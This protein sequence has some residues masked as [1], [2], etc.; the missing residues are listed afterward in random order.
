FL[1]LLGGVLVGV[2]LD[3]PET[4]FWSMSDAAA[5]PLSSWPAYRSAATFLGIAAA[6]CGARWIWRGNPLDAALAIALVLALAAV[7]SRAPAVWLGASA[8]VLLLGLLLT[9]Y[10]MAFIDQL[11]GLPNRR[12]LDETLARLSGD[13]ALAM[14][15]VD[16]FKSFNDTHGH[17]AGDVVLQ[18][19]AKALR[20]HAGGRVFRYGGEE[21]CVVYPSRLAAAAAERLDHARVQ[22]EAERIRVRTAAKGKR[23]DAGH[24]S[25]GEVSVTVSGGC[26]ARDDMHRQAVDVLKAA[27]QALYRA[28]G[29]GRNRVVCA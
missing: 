23:R 18:A 6:I 9:S 11:T 26:A 2:T 7:Q 4:L 19:V 29:K 3:A 22:I 14:V 16:H 10:R 21:F 20:Q 15:D 12:A 8:F 5:W 17:D 25:S 1:L 27:D 28:K 13:Y 24:A